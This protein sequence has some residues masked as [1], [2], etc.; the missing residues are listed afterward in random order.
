MASFFISN[1]YSDTISIFLDKDTF[2]IT[3]IWKVAEKAMWL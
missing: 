3:G 2:K 1:F